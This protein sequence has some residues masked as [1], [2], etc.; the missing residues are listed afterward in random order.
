MLLQM[1]A[2]MTQQLNE[3][4]L[5]YENSRAVSGEVGGKIEELKR[6][7]NAQGEYYTRGY[8]GSGNAPG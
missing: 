6:V 1:L 8:P 5:L 3:M 7:L 2:P 4:K